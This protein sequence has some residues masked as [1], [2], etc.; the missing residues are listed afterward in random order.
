MDH[1]RE[2]SQALDQL[3]GIAA[4]LVV[5][6]HYGIFFFT[7]QDFCSY[8]CHVSPIDFSAFA[9]YTNLFQQ[10]S[11]DLGA[12]AV[13]LF[14]L[15][16]GFFM[17]ALL[18]RYKTGGA[19]LLNRFW[20]LF[21][22]F[23]VTLIINLIFLISLAYYTTGQFPYT[24]PQLLSV[25]TLTRDIFGYPFMDGVIWTL[26]IE[27]KFCLF[28]ALVAPLIKRI[29]FKTL[30]MWQN[31]VFGVALIIY[32]FLRNNEIESLPLLRS[33]SQS[34]ATNLRFFTFML[35]GSLFYLI[36]EHKIEK[37]QGQKLIL[38]LTC[39]FFLQ[40]FWM[41]SEKGFWRYLTS[42]LPSLLVF[43]FVW[44][45]QRPP[46]TTLFHRVIDFITQISYPLYLVHAM[47]G[48]VIMYAFHNQGLNLFIGMGCGVIF[49]LCSATLLH[50]FIETP[51]HNKAKS[52]RTWA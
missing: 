15:L 6:Y 18:E 17:P 34:I 45:H 19:F 52:Y 35:I 22:T 36:Q 30:L 9:P 27:W 28:V 8:L 29:E 3:R 23:A 5:I 37:K 26:E 47:S 2:R 41:L 44:S 42:Y 31:L 10:T 16:S 1:K 50:Y 33:V 4:L 43:A 24:W 39:L 49:S 38:F 32:L 51:S 40:C 46:S 11:F 14:F 48:Y 12:F 7:E 25:I 20:R 21:P 13:S